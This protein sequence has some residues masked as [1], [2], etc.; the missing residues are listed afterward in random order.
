MYSVTRG[1]LASSGTL[2]IRGAGPTLTSIVGTS[3]DDAIA[4]GALSQ[5]TIEAL[6]FTTGAE[7]AIGVTDGRLVLRDLDMPN[8]DN[9]VIVREDV[10]TA[11]LVVEASDVYLVGCIGNTASCSVADSTVGTIGVLGAQATLDVRRVD[12]IGLG[13]TTGLYF[14]S[15]GRAHI[16][17][18]TISNYSRP[19][20]VNASDADVLVERTRF[21]GNTGPMRGAGGG[22]VRLDDVEFRDNIVNDANLTLPAVLHATD[23]VAWRINRALFD[24]NRGGGGGASLGAVVAADPGANVVITNTTFVDNTYRS[25]VSPTPAHAIGVRTTAADPTIMWLFH[26]TMRRPTTVPA[27]TLGSLLAVSGAGGRAAVNTLPMAPARSSG[28]SV[29]QAVGRSNRSATAAAS[30]AVATVN[31]P[32]AQLRLGTLADHGGFTQRFSR[33]RAAC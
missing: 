16:V 33:P 4:G 17:D 26:V 25:G 5:L 7:A 1:P 3:D 2:T 14:S 6:R 23:G 24:G 28:G 9:Q 11:T 13:P 15:N 8:D 10:L 22:M 31:V 20:E 19:I 30:P 27:S 18:A 29:L 21:F 32:A 12:I